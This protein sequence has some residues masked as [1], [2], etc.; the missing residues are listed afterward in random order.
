MLY[1]GVALFASSATLVDVTTV[2]SRFKLD[3]KYATA[4]NF[5]GKVL[6]PAARCLLRP[7]VAE[8]LRKA[9]AF[10]DERH[11]GYTLLL[12]DC[13]RPHSVQKAMWE[14]VKGTPKESYVANPEAGSVHNFGA[15]V[16]LTLADAN[17]AEVDMGTPYDFFGREAQPRHEA[18]LV[19]EGKLS[20]DQVS[21]RRALR[22]AM[23]K[24]GGF[25]SIPNE[26]W[27]FDR[28]RGKALRARYRILDVPL[29]DPAPGPDSATAP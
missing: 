28:V 23:V 10:L 20:K 21:H 4:D 17:G 3:I 14:V 11:P 24:G 25:L 1:L 29:E 8:S 18:A 6:Y 16:D 22:D 12:K 19:A 26:W 13:Y 9:Q 27:H 5:M 15:A 2:D 7:E